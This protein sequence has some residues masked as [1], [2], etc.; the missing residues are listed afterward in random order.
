MFKKDHQNKVLPYF[1]YIMHNTIFNEK[2]MVRSKLCVSEFGEQAPIS[3]YTVQWNSAT[4]W[5]KRIQHALNR[6]HWLV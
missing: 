6:L 3:M 4:R 1:V 2:M 5:Q